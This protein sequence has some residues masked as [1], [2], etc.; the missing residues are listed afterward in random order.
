MLFNAGNFCNAEFVAAEIC[1]C[2]STQGIFVTLS[3]SRQRLCLLHEAGIF[4]NAECDTAVVFVTQDLSGCGP[5]NRVDF[6]NPG[7]D[8]CDVA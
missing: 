4:C 5:S 8:L 7:A 1:T 3:F 2:C 6:C